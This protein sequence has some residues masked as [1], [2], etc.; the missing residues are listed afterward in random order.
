MRNKPA[1]CS[2]TNTISEASIMTRQR[3]RNRTAFGLE[4]LEIRNAPSSFGG[5]AHAVAIA[6]PVHAAAHVRHETDPE[7]NHKKEVQER[8]SSVDSSQDTSTDPGTTS[9]SRDPG[10]TDPNSV[11]PKSDN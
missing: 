10:S 6:Q 2:Q 8:S 1:Q 5:A 11:D 3:I 4:S 7:G 9:I